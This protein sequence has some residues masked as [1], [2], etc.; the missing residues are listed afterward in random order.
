MNIG[1]VNRAINGANSKRETSNT[2][3]LKQCNNNNKI[4]TGTNSET[5]NSATWRSKSS[6]SEH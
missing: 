3:T 1:T 5:L 4:R 2:E 6:S